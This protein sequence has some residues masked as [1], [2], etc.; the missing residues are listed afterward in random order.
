ML[1]I[2]IIECTVGTAAI[3]PVEDGWHVEATFHALA[4]MPTLGAA[5]SPSPHAAWCRRRS[6]GTPRALST[7]RFRFSARAAPGTG[8]SNS[9]ARA[10]QS[11]PPRRCRHAT[12]TPSSWLNSR[13]TGLAT[14]VSPAWASEMAAASDSAVAASTA[15]PRNFFMPATTGVPARRFTRHR[16]GTDLPIACSRPHP[17]GWPGLRH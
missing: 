9:V 14:A 17:M 5:K 11:R 8:R 6:A 1:S 2:S 12:A 3:R 16:C 4:V 13:F 10:G 7:R 15:V